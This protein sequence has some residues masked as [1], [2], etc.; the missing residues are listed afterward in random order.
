MAAKHHSMRELQDMAGVQARTVR[1]WIRQKLIP[2]P[3]GRGRGARYT[4]Q[5]VLLARVVQQL[6]AQRLSLRAIRTR[7]AQLTPEQMAAMLP[8]PRDARIAAD[9]MPAPPPAPSYPST[10]WEVVALMDGLVL[11][12]NSSKAPGLR[13]IANEIYRYYGGLH[14]GGRPAPL[15]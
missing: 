12:V 11:L 13:R 4:E 14:Y 8:K 1:H 2:K 10:S 7:L 6:R 5:H 9:G 15:S 3:L